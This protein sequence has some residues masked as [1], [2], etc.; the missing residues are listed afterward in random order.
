MV[1]EADAV[2][3]ATITLGPADVSRDVFVFV[4]TA[5][6]STQ[7]MFTYVPYA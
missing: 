7:G 1:F 6:N 2:I 3:N 4:T 5:D